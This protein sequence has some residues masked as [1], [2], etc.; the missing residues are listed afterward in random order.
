MKFVYWEKRISAAPS[1]TKLTQ[2]F[3]F[4]AT[5]RGVEKAFQKF[6]KGEN[7]ETAVGYTGGSDSSPDYKKVLYTFCSFLNIEIFFPTER[8]RN[9]GCIPCLT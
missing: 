9:D 6:Y 2:F 8:D 3:F 7:I 5:T 4:V 1:R